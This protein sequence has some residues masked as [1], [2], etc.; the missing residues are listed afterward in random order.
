MVIRDYYFGAWLIKAKGYSYNM[1]CGKLTILSMDKS[2]LTL[3]SKEYTKNHK[4]YYDCVKA[5]VKEANQSRL[6]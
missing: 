4:D 2:T 6:T 1:V 5:L 3:L